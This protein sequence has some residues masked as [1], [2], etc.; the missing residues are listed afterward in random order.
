MVLSNCRRGSRPSKSLT[1]R[2][3]LQPQLLPKP[4]L[5]LFRLAEGL[6]QHQ[7]AQFVE[8]AGVDPVDGGVVTGLELL[9]DA[10]ALNEMEGFDLGGDVFG[11]PLLRGACGAQPDAE[12][13][14]P[15]GVVPTVAPSV[16]T[17]LS[18]VDRP[19]EYTGC[20]IL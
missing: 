12:A 17:S 11:R 20:G 8:I 15:F 7:P 3:S 6:L 13:A 18:V 14:A 16:A 2:A 19:T 10:K 5:Q 9:V 4:E 1:S